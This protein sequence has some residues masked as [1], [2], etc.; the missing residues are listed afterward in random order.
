MFSIIDAMV[1]T[2]SKL[3]KWGKSK[4][5][6]SGLIVHMD[7]FRFKKTC[8]VSVHQEGVPTWCAKHQSRRLMYF[9]VSF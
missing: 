7:M 1:Y 8:G 2:D 5:E 9:I 6:N 4:D 3:L